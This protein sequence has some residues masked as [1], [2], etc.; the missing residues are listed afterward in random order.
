MPE[1]GSGDEQPV[2]TA[3]EAGSPP[4]ELWTV[5]LDRWVA[6]RLDPGALPERDL[7]QAE[8]LRDPK[9]ADRLR[10]RRMVTRAV[11]ASTL[12]IEPRAVDI[13]RT[14]P[15]CGSTEHGRPYVPGSNIMFSVSS[16]GELAVIAVSMHPVGVDIELADSD[17]MPQPHSL[18]PDERDA[19]AELPP[20]RRSDAFLRLWTAKEAVL[21]AGERSLADDPATVDVVAVLYSDSTPVSDRGHV[22]Y[23]RHLPIRLDSGLRAVVALASSH[24]AEVVSRWFR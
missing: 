8:R 21:K 14:C 15:A 17:V 1:L 23:V 20:D 22:W 13:E 7:A 5:D 4:I 24:D 16:S 10:V 11:L 3:S 6:T 18:S 19:L 2:R 12:G 9:G